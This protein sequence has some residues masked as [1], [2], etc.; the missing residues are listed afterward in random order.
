V[1]TPPRNYEL[2]GKARARDGAPSALVDGLR[3]AG[4]RDAEGRHEVSLAGSF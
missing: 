2:N 1:L 4:P 3:M